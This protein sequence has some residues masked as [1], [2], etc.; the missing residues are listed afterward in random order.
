LDQDFAPVTAIVCNEKADQRPDGTV[1]KVATE[2]R[3]NDVTALVTALRLPDEPL[4]DDLCQQDNRTVYEWL[5]LLDRQGRWVHPGLPRD[6]CGQPL[7]KVFAAIR[8]LKRTPASSRTIQD[9]KWSRATAAGCAPQ[10][11]DAAWVIGV[12]FGVREPGRVLLP[13]TEDP[14][15]CLYRVPASEQRTAA[16]ELAGGGPLA[17]DRWAAI[18]EAILASGP[19]KACT[20]PASRFVLLRTSQDGR[21]VY[22]EMDGCQR[23]WALE[24]RQASPQLLALLNDPTE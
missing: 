14:V 6:A 15:R 8:S 16:G 12:R 3:T 2:S 7:P 4:A 23:I 21:R 1:L 5:A 9:P 11:Q 17:T 13:R 20:T 22:V 24:M 10:E 19:A 18:K